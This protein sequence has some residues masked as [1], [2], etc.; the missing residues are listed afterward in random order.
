[1]KLQ[2]LSPAEYGNQFRFACRECGHVKVADARTHVRP[3][4]APD[5][6]VPHYYICGEC[7]ERVLAS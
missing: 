7:M 6:I 5:Y 2:P 1:M 4:I 3:K